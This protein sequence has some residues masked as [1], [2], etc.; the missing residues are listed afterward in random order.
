MVV[1]TERT[2]EASRVMRREDV[3]IK[4]T[5]SFSHDLSN[6]NTKKQQQQQVQHRRAARAG[7]T[8]EKSKTNDARENDDAD[9]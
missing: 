6:N 3:L 9:E 2:N 1:T 7:K 4:A 5:R 8:N